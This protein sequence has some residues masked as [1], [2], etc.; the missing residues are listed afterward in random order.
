MNIF[1]IDMHV[2]HALLP[3]IFLVL[4]DFMLSELLEMMM[5]FN[6]VLV[7]LLGSFLFYSVAGL[8]RF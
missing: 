8:Y 5:I 7:S 3:S 2:S 6:V 4:L 1:L